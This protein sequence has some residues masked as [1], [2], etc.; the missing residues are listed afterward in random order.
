MRDRCMLLVILFVSVSSSAADAATIRVP[1][2]SSTIQGA[3][4]SARN[5]DIVE[6]APG[7]Y[8]E[9]LDFLG[10]AIEVRAPDGATLDAN[11]ETGVRFTNGEDDR[12]KLVGFTITNGGGIHVVGGG[13]YCIH[14]SPRIIDCRIESS[15]ASI[16]GAIYAGGTGPGPTLLRVTFAGNRAAEDGG[17]V[18]AHGY[19]SLR[20]EACRFDENRSEYFGGAVLLRD[21]PAI[22]INDTTF[23]ANRTGAGGG[24]IHFSSLPGNQAVVTSCR[25][26]EN[27][28]GEGGAVSSFGT[29]VFYVD[30]V[31]ANNTA[32]YG[33]AVS[34]PRTLTHFE[35]CT[36]AGNSAASGSAVASE[37]GHV[38]IVRSHFESHRTSLERL[39]EGGTCQLISMTSVSI[40]DSTFVDNTSADTGGALV[41]TDCADVRIQSS[42]FLA[43][44][45]S[46]QGG[47]IAMDRCEGSLLG[48]RFSSNTA[49]EGGAVRLA[50]SDVFV[51]GSLFDSN[52]AYRGSAIH[53]SDMNLTMSSSTL[54]DGAAHVSSAHLHTMRSN[55]RIVDSIVWD[56]YG[57]PL[58]AFVFDQSTSEV[59]TSVIQGGWTGDG[60]L[61]VDP[62]FVNSQL[63]DYHLR[64]DSPCVD[65]GSS[66]GPFPDFDGDNGPLDGD[67]DGIAQP[68]IGADELSRE[69][70]ARFG[71]VGA[72]RDAIEPVLFVNGSYGDDRRHVT[73]DRSEPLRIEMF[74]PSEGPEPARF[75]AYAY[76]AHPDSITLSPQPFGL[77]IASFPTPLDRNAPQQHV[78]VFNN[79]GYEARL[80]AADTPSSP[81]PSVLVQR[82]RPLSFPAELTIQGIIEDA[83]S[84]ADAPVSLT[85]AV[86]VTF[87]D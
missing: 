52:E 84:N 85:N 47:A 67:G 63:G 27:E 8:V 49:V 83:G 86:V 37:R 50:D 46:L 80:G 53:A 82:A 75:V 28:G 5:G 11:G 24:A 23:R 6:V 32:W 35:G 62:R 12:T 30:C 61:D 72:A 31:F 33:G 55:V 59:S 76:D 60:N 36:F 66:F 43:N 56:S 29:D 19:D 73:L 16:G 25:F 51:G 48:S 9:N 26:E 81:A 79:L 65:A 71:S 34:A 13:I 10:K 77:G 45:A 69:I 38:G 14:S 15:E 3:I 78:A 1:A 22:E 42:R 74:A 68:D 2:D 39:N 17:A 87:I 70:A 57:D 20:L 44:R 54:A 41:V 4:V 18:F 58:D 21:I 7:T 40:L 64:L